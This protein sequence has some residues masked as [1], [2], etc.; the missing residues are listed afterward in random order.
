MFVRTSSSSPKEDLDCRKVRDCGIW[1][2]R[3]HCWVWEQGRWSCCLGSLCSMT[4]ED[5]W[6]PWH[7]F[8]WMIPGML[9]HHPLNAYGKRY[10]NGWTLARSEWL[11]RDGASSAE[12]LR[13]RIRRPSSFTIPWRTTARTSR[14]SA[15]ERRMTWTV[16]WLMPIGRWLHQWWASWRGLPDNAATIYATGAHMFSSW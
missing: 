9:G 2:T 13:S 11:L 12:G 3:A 10:I 15:R 1:N 6:R 7:A 8:M 14:W 16:L 4:T 5:S